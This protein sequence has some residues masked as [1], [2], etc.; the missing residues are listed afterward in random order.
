MTTTS[1]DQDHPTVTE[2]TITLPAARRRGV[3]KIVVLGWVIAALGVG[4]AIGRL[5][6]AGLLG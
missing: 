5:L 6:P 3:A 4:F 1:T 2:G